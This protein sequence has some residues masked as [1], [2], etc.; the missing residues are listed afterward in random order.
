MPKARDNFPKA[1]VELEC[2]SMGLVIHYFH[3]I[4]FNCTADQKKNMH[5]MYTTSESRYSNI[6]I[7]NTSCIF[8]SICKH[9]WACLRYILSS[10]ILLST[11]LSYVYY[12]QVQRSPWYQKPENRPTPRMRVDGL[13]HTLYMGLGIHYFSCN[14]LYLY[15]GSKI[16]HASS[17]QNPIIQPTTI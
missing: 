4:V 2:E 5:Y 6:K 15:S 7:T 14:Y 11:F 1:R 16:K 12:A 17:T 3:V 10:F 13:V 8:A 9:W